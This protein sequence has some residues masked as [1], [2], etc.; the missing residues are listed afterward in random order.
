VRDESISIGQAG[1]ITLR[2]DRPA[3][4][5]DD[6]SWLIIPIFVMGS[7][8]SASAFVELHGW[9]TWTTGIIAYLD[10]LAES[11][12]GWV[13]SRP[14][15]DDEVDNVSFDASHDGRGTVSL[16][17]GLRA[18]QG[19]PETE[20]DWVAEAVVRID[21]GALRTVAHDVGSLIGARP[22]QFVL[23]PTIRPNRLEIEIL[24]D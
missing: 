18:G 12:K 19:W 4:A 17:V 16:L 14:W 8:I 24:D 11:W 1:G 15:H 5:V 7:G 10:G 20:R 23:V 13:G 6:P 21:A 22:R 9:G 2:F 3:V